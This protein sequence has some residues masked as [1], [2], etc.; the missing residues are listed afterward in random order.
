MALRYLR[1]RSGGSLFAASDPDLAFLPVRGFHLGPILCILRFMNTDLMWRF[2]IYLVVAFGCALALATAVVPHYGH[3]ALWFSVLLVGVAPYL[4]FVVLTEISPSPPLVL[5]GLVVLGLDAV[6]KL[7]Q[8]FV[9]FDQYASG[10]IYYVPI[11]VTIAILVVALFNW[12]H[13]VSSPPEPEQSN[14]DTPAET[15]DA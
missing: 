4:V 14:Q 12:E 5:G 3:H 9:T 11:A 13:G 6:V 10:V 8:R 1:F 7:F 2:A 15:S